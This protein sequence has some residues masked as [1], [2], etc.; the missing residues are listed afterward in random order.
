MI[1]ILILYILNRHNLTIYKLG[2]VIEEL[3]SPFAKPSLG[4]IAPA[5][6][7]LSAAGFLTYDEKFSQGGLKSKTYSITSSG[8]AQLQ[9]LLVEFK[10]K[11]LHSTPKTASILLL[12]LDIIG[13]DAKD[14]FLKNIGNNLKIYKTTVE[15]EINNPYI[16]LNELQIAVLKN[17]A[18]QA[19]SLLALVEGLK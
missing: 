8:A 15:N 13:E 3:F 18:A 16:R 11:N 14:K 2:R 5:L 19:T 7:K 6:N 17:A 9:K 4:S 10:F 12:C 1:E